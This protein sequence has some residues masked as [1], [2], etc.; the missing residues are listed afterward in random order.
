ML[1]AVNP[2]IRQGRIDLKIKVPH[3]FLLDRFVLGQ[4]AA[5]FLFGIMSFTV[6]L[7]AGNLLFRLADLVIQR[8]VPLWTVTRLFFYSL[9]AVVVL[10]IP[11]SC[12][13]ASLLG[14]GQMSANSELVALKAAGISFGRIVRPVV[15]AGAVMS[16][17]AFVMN[18]TLVPLSERAAANVLRFDVLQKVPPLFSENVFIRD[19]SDGVL[20]R[21]IYIGSVRPRTGVIESI[22]LQEFDA[23][24]IRHI[25]SAP[26]GYWQDGAWWL[27]SGHVF[28]V[29]PSGSV[30]ALFDFEKQRM[31]LLMTPDELG[32]NPVD[33][34]EMGLKELYH[35]IQ[36][37][38]KK[39]NFTGKLWMLFNLRIAVPW[40]SIVLVLV[41]STIGSRPQR[42]S[43]SMGLGLSVVI[44]FAYYVILSLCKSL[45]EADFIPGV[46]AAW[47]PN[48][49]FL[50]VGVLL[51]GRANKFA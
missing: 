27:E 40:A 45:G 18:E 24:K 39:G 30:K 33:P 46:L 32:A 17:V 23:G 34:S 11:M 5:P 37:A 29:E 36:N 9:P 28:E 22:L 3:R 43:S 31:N 12:L 16:L 35:E 19:E 51:A 44:V 50:M 8:G 38:Q 1:R 48:A 26:R 6:I 41:G 10:T 13:L 15:I 7:V 47:T 14:F 25:I 42:A 20:R 2:R 21:V 49:V 4:M